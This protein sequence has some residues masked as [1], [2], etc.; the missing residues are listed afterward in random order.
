M[1]FHYDISRRAKM[2]GAY[3]FLIAQNIQFDSSDIFKQSDVSE[4]VGYDLIKKNALIKRNHN[5]I[6]RSYKIAS[7]QI[8]EAN[9][10]LQNDYLGLNEKRL[11]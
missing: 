7:K 4:R 1:P 2:Q 11:T 8:R 5:R 6:G 9:Y 10:I 3:D